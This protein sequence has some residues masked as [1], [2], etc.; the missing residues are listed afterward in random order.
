MQRRR[1]L[2]TIN[3]QVDDE[4]GSESINLEELDDNVLS[5]TA[6]SQ[7][8]AQLQMHQRQP[9]AA[10]AHAPHPVNHLSGIKPFH[11]LR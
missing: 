5:P 7:S 3:Y 11:K 6:T 9:R 8:T 4:R 10:V 1:H 2:C